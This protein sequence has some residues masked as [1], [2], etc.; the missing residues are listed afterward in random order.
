MLLYGELAPKLFD[1]LELLGK[2][3]WLVVHR[4]GGTM[5]LMYAQQSGSSVC[6]RAVADQVAEC[7]TNDVALHAIRP[8]K[9]TL[10]P[11][12]LKCLR[13]LNALSLILVQAADATCSLAG[14]WL[15]MGPSHGQQAAQQL[16]SVLPTVLGN[17]DTDLQARVQLVLAQALLAAAS[18]ADL[19]ADPEE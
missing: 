13:D 19:K 3:G 5:R 15:A 1:L 16:R 17:A 6:C 10:T 7:T 11:K 8:E 4:E 2:P 18:P 9:F 14:I 12:M